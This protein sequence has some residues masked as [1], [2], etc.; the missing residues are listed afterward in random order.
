[1]HQ[2]TLKMLEQLRQRLE[3][4]EDK[5]PIVL[6]NVGNTVSSTIPIV[7]ENLRTNNQITPDSSNLLIGFGVGLSWAGCVWKPGPS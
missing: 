4:P 3:L 5:L 7:L 6:E 2:A 1:M